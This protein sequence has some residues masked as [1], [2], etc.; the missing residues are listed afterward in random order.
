M[1][2]GDLFVRILGITSGPGTIEDTVQK[3]GNSPA[4]KAAGVKAG[5]LFSAGLQSELKKAATGAALLGGA[6]LLKLGNDLSTT[7]AKFKADTGATDAEAAKAQT[8][9]MA[10]YKTNVEG[11]TTLGGVLGAVY[12]DLHL[13]GQAAQDAA[14]MVLDYARA[15]GQD[16]VAAVGTL[17]DLTAVYN[18][19]ASDQVAIL[20]Q[21]VASHQ[22]YG[23]S[24]ADE[25]SV[26]VAIGPAL[27]AANL[28]YSDGIGL[29]NLF[30]KAGV[31]ASAAPLALNQALHKIKSPEELQTLITAI[32]TAKTRFDAG[33]IASA[34]FGARAGQKLAQALYGTTGSLDSFTVSSDDAAGAVKKAS[35]A[36]ESTPLEQ[37]KIALHSIT[38]P[39]AEFGSSF[40]PLILGLTTATPLLGKFA[41]LG[42]ILAGGVL[43]GIVGLGRSIATALGIELPATVAAAEATGTA[44]GAAEASAHAAAVEAGA[45]TEQAAKLAE[46]VPAE[47]EI[48][49]AAGTAAGTAEVAAETAV[50]VAGQA[51]IAA[52]AIPEAAAGGSLLGA[53][54]GGALTFGLLAA[55]AGLWFEVLQTYNSQKAAIDAEAND[56]G[57]SVGAEIANG[58]IS[59]LETSR[60]AIQA[61]IDKLNATW[62]LGI[63][64]GDARAKL[65]AQLTLVDDAIAAHMTRDQLLVQQGALQ[66]QIASIT[67][68]HIRGA[69]APGGVGADA[70]AQLAIV[71][72]ALAR[73]GTF[74]GNLAHD[75]PDVGAAIQKGIVNPT[76]AGLRGLNPTLRAA[77][78]AEIAA[79]NG[80]LLDKTGTVNA[81][82]ETALADPTRRNLA[83][84]AVI[85][86]RAGSDTAFAVAK[87]I[88]DARNAVTSA[89]QQLISDEK[90]A[91]NPAKEIAYDVGL[92]TS[93]AIAKGLKSGDPAVRAQAK[94]TIDL[95]RARIVELILSG[96]KV[97]KDTLTEL[98]RAMHSKDPEVRAQ[99]K[100][101]KALLE[102]KLA[103]PATSSPAKVTGQ[104]AATDLAGGLLDKAS[105]VGSA[106]FT[107]G[108]FFVDTFLAVI[109]GAAGGGSSTTVVVPHQVAPG[110]FAGGVTNFEGGL[111][112]V[113][114]RGPELAFLAKG[115][116]IAPNDKLEGLGGTMIGPISLTVDASGHKDPRAV[117]TA[118]RQGV[119]DAMADI[120]RSQRARLPSGSI[121]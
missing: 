119:A 27:Q 74:A 59:Q 93:K 15:T 103:E 92:L 17:R 3:V 120:L 72:A 82:V 32:Q 5:G 89:Y 87:G 121:A 68:Q 70:A 78:Q 102:Q 67:S 101:T 111:A 36:I 41:G 116:N 34:A 13:T 85:G 107:L 96:G 105:V 40:G 100:S 88:L 21:L 91:M 37:F 16:A 63:F 115:T 80:G 118:V 26:L 39:M 114:E 112:L 71:D 20:D 30:T 46:E 47:I 62:D 79:Y 51:E 10:L 75:M 83:K 106:A 61:G 110:N 22:K 76:V 73:T 28:G 90:T 25:Q 14:Q 53:A 52:A 43:K 84:L 55:A 60:A 117:G 6:A 33:T 4:V 1:T 19:S 56:I 49:T 57:K 2:I 18:L 58:S 11:L 48:G 108:K 9:I 23:T 95:I 24:V 12:T 38:G 66:A 99:A 81:A 65:E 69:F 45:A 35:D 64:T 42:K 86:L 98:N 50:V 31:D 29:L 113:G 94:G 54:M 104:T 109:H 77:A 8:S 97:G 44:A 7:M